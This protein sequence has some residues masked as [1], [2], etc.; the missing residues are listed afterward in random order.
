[1]D[2]LQY[3]EDLQNQDNV[4]E[5]EQNAEEESEDENERPDVQAPLQDDPAVIQKVCIICNKA[6]RKRAT[7]HLAYKEETIKRLK[8][9][10]ETIDDMELWKGIENARLGG[11]N[12]FYHNMCKN[13]LESRSESV[14]T[15]K[16]SPTKWHKKRNIN[17]MVYLDLCSF[18]EENVLKN[19]N[20][21]FFLF[22]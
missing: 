1:M 14:V 21:Y 11:V 5:E 6:R 22:L 4:E 20:C 16:K 3:P 19:Q 17:A 15:S 10:A 9:K 2:V 8:S 7:L 12:I 18:I 13:D